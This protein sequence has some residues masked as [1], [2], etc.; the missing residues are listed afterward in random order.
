MKKIAIIASIMAVA[1]G[2]MAQGTVNF[3]NGA[4]S[5]AVN[6]P[7]FV[8]SGGVTNLAAA[9][10]SAQLYYNTGGSTTF[11]S[12]TPLAGTGTPGTGIVDYSTGGSAGFFF[13]GTTAI[14]G[15]AGGS[16]INIIVAGFQKSAGID[17]AS[18]KAA[19]GL[20]GFS[21]PVTVTL[22]SGLNTAPNL[23]GLQ[24]FNIAAVPE[25]STIMLGVLG[26]AA[27]LFRR[28]K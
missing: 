6:A 1:A 15:V 11:S 20:V 4:G 19:G 24:S 23:V 17:Y 21:N 2:A 27:L 16:T 9:G 5:P 22:A 14:P 26:G 12:F 28:R 13:G 3:A 18:A 8:V 10:Y 25:P 7:D